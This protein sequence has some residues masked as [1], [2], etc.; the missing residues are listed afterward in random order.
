MSSEQSHPEVPPMNAMA[1]KN[2]VRLAGLTQKQIA[3]A[4]GVDQG[5][6]CHVLNGNKGWQGPKGR[7]IMEFIAERLGLPVTTVFP[8]SERRKRPFAEEGKAA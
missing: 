8:F 2:A 3:E 5:M 1:R 4:V 6:V 7:R